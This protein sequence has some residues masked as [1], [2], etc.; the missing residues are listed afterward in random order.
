[1]STSANTLCCAP[2]QTALRALFLC[3]FRFFG[4]WSVDFFGTQIMTAFTDFFCNPPFFSHSFFTSFYSAMTWLTTRHALLHCARRAVIVMKIII[5]RG[6]IARNY[7]YFL[8]VNDQL[9]TR[10][11]TTE[12]TC[13][14]SQNCGTYIS[15]TV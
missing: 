14:K 2:L 9:L 11:L 4:C 12:Y 15:N 8:H 10:I 13:T 7:T 6:T 5:T 1:M 3:L